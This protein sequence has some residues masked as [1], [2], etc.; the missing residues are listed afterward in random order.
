MN[1]TNDKELNDAIQT[2]MEVARQN[3]GWLL[4]VGI[5]FVLLG[6]IGL[7][8][9]VALTLTSIL[10]LGAF[11][12]VGGVFSLFYTITS[13]HRSPIPWFRRFWAPGRDQDSPI[14]HFSCQGTR[15]EKRFSCF[16]LSQGLWRMFF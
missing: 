14:A 11:L 15:Q 6:T 7:G 10:F 2:R 8:M 16:L 4:T 13:P 9:T 12:L 3:W 1:T 5:L